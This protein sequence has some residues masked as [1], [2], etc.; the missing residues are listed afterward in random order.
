MARNTTSL[1]RNVVLF[2]SL[3]SFANHAAASNLLG[4]GPN[5]RYL[6]KDNLPIATFNHCQSCE[7]SANHSLVITTPVPILYYPGCR[8]IQTC[9]SYGHCV[10]IEDC[11]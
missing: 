3:A 6:P 1:V 4:I 7:K 9:D 8:P 5:P 2:V 11:Y 10:Q